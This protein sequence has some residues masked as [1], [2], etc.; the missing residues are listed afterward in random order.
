MVRSLMKA[1]IFL[2]LMIVSQLIRGMP[3]L[4]L[5]LA[6]MNCLI[7]MLSLAQVILLYIKIKVRTLLAKVTLPA[8]D[9]VR[10]FHF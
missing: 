9:K 8:C 7:G 10:P 2:G 5:S 1:P 6:Q 3:L 4:K